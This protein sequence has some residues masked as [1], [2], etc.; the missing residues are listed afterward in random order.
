MAAGEYITIEI[1]TKYP[2]SDLEG[3]SKAKP[4]VNGLD[5]LSAGLTD[6]HQH[7]GRAG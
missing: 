7:R 1:L 2:P 6:G 5:S 4:F 3:E